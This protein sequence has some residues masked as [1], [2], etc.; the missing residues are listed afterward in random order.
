MPVQNVALE[1]L[2]NPPGLHMF[3]ISR[4][5]R[6][7]LLLGSLHSRLQSYNSPSR[8]SLPAVD[9]FRLG[10]QA[11]NEASDDEKP[12]NSDME[13]DKPSKDSA[14]SIWKLDKT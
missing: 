1:N 3:S 10:S 2:E 9:Q 7:R 14:I 4:I 5:E 6:S 13:V 8:V 12:G 11:S